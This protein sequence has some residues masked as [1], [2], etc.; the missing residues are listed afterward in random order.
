L[1]A[2]NESPTL[3][4]DSANANANSGRGCLKRDQNFI[5]ATADT[6][7]SF[8]DSVVLFFLGIIFSPHHINAGWS[9]VTSQLIEIERKALPA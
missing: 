7:R 6:T 1:S 2:F 8:D 3:S 4:C 9:A 5:A